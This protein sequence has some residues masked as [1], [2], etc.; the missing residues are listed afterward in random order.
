MYVFS[1][2]EMVCNNESYG[3][4]LQQEGILCTG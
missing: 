4:S 1:E 3:L 2:W